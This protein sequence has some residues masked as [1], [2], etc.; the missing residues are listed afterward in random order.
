M[1]DWLYPITKRSGTHF[2]DVHTGE[3][4]PVSFESFRDHLVTGRIVDDWWYVHTN[5]RRIS[6]GDRLWVYTGDDDLGVI[7]TGRIREVG[8]VIPDGPAPFPAVIWWDL[9]RAR[10]RL[11]VEHPYP[12]VRVRRWLPQQKAAVVGLDRYPRLVGELERW[13]ATRRQELRATLQPLGLRTRRLVSV[14]AGRKGIADLRH[15]DVLARVHRTLLAAEFDVGVPKT[16]PVRADLVAIK[17][18]QALLVEAKTLRAGSAGRD[19][20]RAAL[21]QLLEYRWWLRRDAS[22]AG[23]R[24]T[25]WAVFERQPDAQVVEFLESERILVSWCKERHLRH[26]RGSAARLRAILGGR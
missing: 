15:D 21:G 5:Y 3:N 16:G 10:S 4:V 2:E 18:T 19:E 12:A 20:A 25:P 24:I 7:G 13:V 23:F 14:P 9:D 26:A 8:V 1:A 6:A 11:L 17:G 22:W